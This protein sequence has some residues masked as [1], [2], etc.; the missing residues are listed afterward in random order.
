VVAEAGA[1][2]RRPSICCWRSSTRWFAA[3]SLSSMACSRRPSA[4]LNNFECCRCFRSRVT[5]RALAASKPFCASSC[6]AALCP[7][8]RSCS[9]PRA[10]T[11]A[12][13]DARCSLAVCC[14]VAHLSSSDWSCAP[15]VQIADIKRALESACFFWSSRFSPCT[16]PV[17]AAHPR[18]RTR[19]HPQILDLLLQRRPRCRGRFRQCLHDE[20]VR[21]R[22]PHAKAAVPIRRFLP[23]GSPAH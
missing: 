1:F 20:T 6:N 9:R 8:F 3:A 7:S 2:R 23:S 16:T 14:N 18:V 11:V 17:R 4:N 5:N 12:A 10:A 19:S 13:A 21:R 15:S 22:R